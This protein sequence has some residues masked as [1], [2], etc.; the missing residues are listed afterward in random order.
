M[1]A[2]F[3]AIV[4]T[5]AEQRAYA[6]LRDTLSSRA[7]SVRLGKDILFSGTASHNTSLVLPN[8]NG[9]QNVAVEV[10]DSRMHLL[11]T[12][13]AKQNPPLTTSIDASTTSPV[14][15]DAQAAR[16]VLMRPDD[17]QHYSTIPY[18]N[19][20]FLVYTLLNRD[21]GG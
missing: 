4:Y 3:G 6:D 2:I 20:R 18:Q 19:Q 15:W 5:Q 10:L 12:T 13:S 16:Q 21:F 11:A 7:A 14:P 17:S 1:L 9:P 8:V